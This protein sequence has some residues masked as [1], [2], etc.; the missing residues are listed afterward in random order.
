MIAIMVLM[1]LCISKIVVVD[2]LGVTDKQN[3]DPDIARKVMNVLGGTIKNSRDTVLLS[4]SKGT[5]R[6]VGD[7]ENASSAYDRGSQGEAKLF[8]KTN[9]DNKTNG[10]E[11]HLRPSPS[12][13]EYTG[14]PTQNLQV[15]DPVPEIGRGY[16]ES[17]LLNPLHAR[18]LFNGDDQQ[19]QGRNMYE[20][21]SMQSYDPENLLTPYDSNQGKYIPF[22]F[23]GTGD[24]F[25]GAPGYTEAPLEDRMGFGMGGNRNLSD[26]ARAR[27]SFI[28]LKMAQS[29]QKESML[30]SSID[31][32]LQD[33]DQVAEKIQ[34]TQKM[35]D[36]MMSRLHTKKNHL[37][38]LQI[39][40]KEVEVQRGRTLALIRLS[41]NELLKLSKMI[42]D[43]RSKLALLEDE[44]K[45]FSDRIKK[46]DEE[47]DVGNR[48]LQLDETRT[49]E[50]KRSI[51]ELE[52]MYNVLKIRNNELLNER[53]KES[54]IRNK[55]EMEVERF[56]RSAIDFI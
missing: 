24:S 6:I 54:A 22:S 14:R 25:T 8:A 49:E 4:N 5:K 20:R 38:N 50:I 10:R 16:Q 32:L 35:K 2:D 19:I 56:D 23:G 18:S 39:N 55:L 42:D 7:D 30:Q 3:R 13:P 37:R 27:K 29:K 48:E 1:Q 12:K 51:E 46:Y 17:S 28:I 53:N 45:I 9:D 43:Q 31:K 15:E 36:G 26:E 41:R 34:D 47:Y 44:E 11:T 33:I 52:R 21:P 40:I